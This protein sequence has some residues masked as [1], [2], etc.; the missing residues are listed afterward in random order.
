VISGECISIPEARPTRVKYGILQLTRVVVSDVRMM[1]AFEGRTFRPLGG[2]LSADGR[3]AQSDRRFPHRVHGP[4]A[5][6]VRPV[7][8]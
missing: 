7:R 1:V 3:I 5:C 8:R 4:T 2:W 6:T